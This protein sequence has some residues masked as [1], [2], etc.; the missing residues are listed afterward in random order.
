MPLVLGK[1]GG[2]T[3]CNSFGSY[4]LKLLSVVIDTEV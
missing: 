3:D 4:A 2:I 1:N